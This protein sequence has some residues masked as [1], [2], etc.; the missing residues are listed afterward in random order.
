ML[1]SFSWGI[2]RSSIGSILKILMQALEEGLRRY[3]PQTIPFLL[4]KNYRKLVS[5][6]HEGLEKILL[7]ET[8]GREHY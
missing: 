4:L 1:P 5:P 8:E 3:L 6:N 2:L 7:K